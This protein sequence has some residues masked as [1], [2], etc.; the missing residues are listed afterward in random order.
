MRVLGNSKGPNVPASCKAF[1]NSLI[2]PTSSFGNILNS[3]SQLT[4]KASNNNP[5]IELDIRNLCSGKLP[6]KS[7]QTELRPK[8]TSCIRISRSDAKSSVY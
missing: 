2:T 7:D 5:H 8:S 1:Q 3:R 6:V 4:N